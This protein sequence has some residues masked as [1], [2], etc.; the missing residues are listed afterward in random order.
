MAEKG[1]DRHPWPELPPDDDSDADVQ[2][3][4]ETGWGNSSS[5][6]AVDSSWD[7]PTTA[8]ADDQLKVDS[9]TPETTE[10]TTN[11]PETFKEG[12]SAPEARTNRIKFSIDDVWRTENA[13]TFAVNW[14]NSQDTAFEGETPEGFNYLDAPRSIWQDVE[15]AAFMRLY[16][17]Q[18]RKDPDRIDAREPHT[19]DLSKSQKG[20]VLR[21]ITVMRLKIAALRRCKGRG[22]A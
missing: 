13:I 1:E 19:V 3:N 10:Q 9:F 5:E 7:T 17:K 15:E 14:F 12:A 2:S 4:V 11:K 6:P 18:D 16:E 20:E 8:A 22:E 21:E